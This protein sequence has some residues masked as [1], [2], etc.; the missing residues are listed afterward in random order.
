[1]TTPEEQIKTKLAEFAGVIPY[2]DFT[3]LATS[4]AHIYS[5]PLEEA[6]ALIHKLRGKTEIGSQEFEN[7]GFGKNNLWDGQ[8][9]A[10]NFGH[11]PPGDLAE[12]KSSLRPLSKLELFSYKKG[13]IVRVVNNDQAPWGGE[14][15]GVIE[16]IN[17]QNTFDIRDV[18][19]GVL[20]VN[21]PA[22]LLRNPLGEGRQDVRV[23]QRRVG[24]PKGMGEGQS[25]SGDP[26]TKR[27]MPSMYMMPRGQEGKD[28]KNPQSLFYKKAAK[29]RFYCKECNRYFDNTGDEPDQQAAFDHALKTKHRIDLV[30]N[31]LITRP[32]GIREMQFQS[33]DKRWYSFSEYSDPSLDDKMWSEMLQ[34][35]SDTFQRIVVWENAKKKVI[36]GPSKPDL[37]KEASASDEENEERELASEWQ[38]FITSTEEIKADTLKWYTQ[39]RNENR[40]EEIFPSKRRILQ[41]VFPDVENWADPKSRDISKE[42]VAWT[43]EFKFKIGDTVEIVD[44]QEVTEINLLLGDSELK[45]IDRFGTIQVAYTIEDQPWYSVRV[46]LPKGP[47]TLM[48]VVHVVEV[49]EDNL[50]EAPK[51]EQLHKEGAWYPK[52]SPRDTYDRPETIS[53]R[54]PSGEIVSV[55]LTPMGQSPEETA[56]TIS[57]N[58]T[59]DTGPFQYQGIIM[60]TGSGDKT[61]LTFDWL[62]RNGGMKGSHGPDLSVKHKKYLE[63][64]ISFHSFLAHLVQYRKHKEIDKFYSSLRKEGKG[65]SPWKP[66]HPTYKMGDRVRVV[67]SSDGKTW[68][69]CMCGVYNQERKSGQ[70]GQFYYK[71]ISGLG[72]TILTVHPSNH[73]KSGFSFNC[74]DVLVDEVKPYHLNALNLELNPETKIKVEEPSQDRLDDLKDKIR[75]AETLGNKDLAKQLLEQYMSLT[76]TKNL[77]KEAHCGPCAPIKME[78]IRMLSDMHFEFNNFD[79]K[80]LGALGAQ[81][82]EAD[83]SHF[84]KTLDE[85]L[86]TIEV[87]TK[88]EGKLRK[89]RQIAITLFEIQYHIDEGKFK[90]DKPKN[91]KLYAFLLNNIVK[92]YGEAAVI[93]VVGYLKGSVAFPSKMLRSIITKYN[94]VAPIDRGDISR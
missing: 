25:D 13:D 48:L 41:R 47:K 50:R 63:E 51:Q 59:V 85:V 36:R 92:D 33:V 14:Y 49:A 70:P 15:K 22:H 34:Y 3:N 7:Q 80:Y 42:A 65:P 5:I 40:L 75:D 29:H 55:T 30:P 87:N 69:N 83:S 23:Q 35:K 57:W 90:A 26:N 58:F 71:D 77:C 6:T 8:D 28:I 76:S 11:R 72:G 93:E 4:V 54:I 10:H 74:Y 44:P 31:L 67:K 17:A 78:A 53:V 19:T 60:L 86:G 37:T 39:Y 9:R 62:P 66:Q 79:K 61:T 68:V 89:L 91:D 24:D 46:M 12:P 1:M 20:N 21:Q 56:E 16:A 88:T 81:S 32:D 38:D 84:A 73:E 18:A 27:E 82:E 45:Q 64:Y 94:L 2:N 43:N 52:I